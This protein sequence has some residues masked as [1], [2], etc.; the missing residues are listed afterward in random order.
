MTA[1]TPNPDAASLP[2][3]DP[4]APPADALPTQIQGREEKPHIAPRCACGKGCGD[5]PEPDP[6]GR[7]RCTVCSC[8]TASPDR[9]HGWCR[10]G[11]IAA[12]SRGL[13]QAWTTQD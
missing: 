10:T 1:K 8:F 6:I 2:G 9:R 12:W 3:F 5:Y 13:D 11:S 4:P 7:Y